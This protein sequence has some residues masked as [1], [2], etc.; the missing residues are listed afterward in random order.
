MA[1]EVNHQVFP[2][3]T[4]VAL[5]LATDVEAERRM[6]RAPFPAPIATFEVA[7]DGTLEVDGVGPGRLG[8]SAKTSPARELHGPVD[9]GYDYVEFTIDPS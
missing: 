4:E 7:E 9:E 1:V 5:H 8:V 6:G 3:G 2:P